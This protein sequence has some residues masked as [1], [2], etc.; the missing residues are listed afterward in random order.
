MEI[1]NPSHMQSGF[2]L[3]TL[4]KMAKTATDDGRL[5]IGLP[6]ERAN[7]E[8]RICLT[9]GGVS[10]LTANGHRVVMETG[11]GSGANF[12]DQDYSEAGAE[13]CYDTRELFEKSEI[14]VKVA[15]PTEQELSFMK[16][17]QILLSAVHLGGVRLDFFQTLIS[18]NITAIGFEF[19][20]APDGTYPI[21]RMMHEITG[22]VAVQLAAHYLETNQR[23]PGIVIGGIS[24]IPPATVVILGAGIIAE[25]AARTALGFGAQVLVMDNDLG[26]LRRL[27]NALDRR[28]ITAMAN[29][30]YLSAAVKSAD[31]LIGAAL[32]EGNRAPCWVTETMVSTM[33]SG[34]VIV[35]AV[36]DQGGCVETSVLTSHSNPVVRRH[37]VVHYGVPN[38]PANVART[39][40]YALNNVLVPFLVE[41]GDAGGLQ[42]ALW[43]HTTLRNGVYVYK[44]NITKKTVSKQFDVPFR[45]IDMLIASRI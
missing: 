33:K 44:R 1:L 40:T 12:T 24:G 20:E 7:D 16:T 35:D 27:E 32:T 37:D 15:P 43:S 11:A 4:E 10:V 5:V 8:T 30:Q 14:L 21:V 39:A 42:S 34:A 31:V 45:D 17:G 26:A 9:P 23:G 3:K 29:H 25:Y 22:S 28:I 41:I 38:I 19:L 6:K 36:I 2:G 18:K 13:I